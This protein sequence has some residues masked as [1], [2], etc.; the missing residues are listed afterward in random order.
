MESVFKNISSVL[1]CIE[2]SFDGKKILVVGDLMLDRYVRGTV[3]R[4]SPEAPVPIVTVRS[5]YE[6]AGGAGNV[7]TNVACLGLEVC[8]CGFA[9]SDQEGETLCRILSEAGVSVE[10]VVRTSRRTTTKTRIIGG[11]QQMLRLDEEDV[12]ELSPGDYENLLVNIKDRITGDISGVI[13]SDYAKGTLTPDI[14]REVI[15]LCLMRR[16]PVFVDPKG[17]EYSKYAGATA[18]TPNRAELA[19]VA[20]IEPFSELDSIVA[21]A[22][23]ISS[24]LGL[25]FVVVTLGEHGLVLVDPE[26]YEH[27]PAMARDVFDVT[28]A[29]D[30]VVAVLASGIVAGLDVADAVRLANLAAGIVVGKSGTAAV[31]RTELLEAIALG[32]AR[33]LSDKIHTLDGLLEHVK[34]W[35]AHG[36]VIGFTNGCFDVLHAGHVTYLQKARAEA[37][38]LIVGLNSDSSVRRLKGPGR[39]IIPQEQRAIVLAA[40][41]SVDAIV[42]FEEDTPIELINA[43]RPDVLIKGSDYTEDRVVGAREVKSWGGR[44]VLVPLVEGQS[45]TKIVSKIV[46]GAGGK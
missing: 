46:Q 11:H 28:G 19:S 5:R 33:Q 23:R 14:C 25:E 30:T 32:Q 26:S 38:R 45:T 42:V 39:P 21:A 10:C 2:K 36:E 35:H 31:R 40:L 3:S 34:Q 8:A 13:I 43:I 17:M 24:E 37:D 29:G 4:I 18:I 1:N 20:H 16:V 15:Q 7:A 27:I 22:R 9:G 6:A 44:V 12:S 41:A